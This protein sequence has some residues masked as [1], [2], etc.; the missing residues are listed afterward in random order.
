MGSYTSTSKEKRGEK[1]KYIAFWETSPEDFDKV[2]PKFREIMAARETEPEKFPKII[3]PPHNM[4]GEL[5]GCAIYED[6]TEEQINNLVIH[7]MPEI[8]FK[9]VPLSEPAKFI[10]QYLKSK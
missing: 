2:I 9:F 8:T 5:K 6:P 3:F 1:M 4:G 7:Y 10:E